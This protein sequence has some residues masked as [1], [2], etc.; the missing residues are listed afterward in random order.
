MHELYHSV[1][2]TQPNACLVSHQLTINAESEQRKK[3]RRTILSRTLF[4]ESTSALMLP[5]T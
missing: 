1:C 4:W 2:T 3:Q 5:V